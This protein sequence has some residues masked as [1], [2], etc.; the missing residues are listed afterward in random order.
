MDKTADFDSKTDPARPSPA[1]RARALALR[2]WIVLLLAA[3][4]FVP[5]AGISSYSVIP[6]QTDFM[7]FYAV[8]TLVRIGEGGAAWHDQVLASAVSAAVGHP[9]VGLH[10]LYP[11]GMLFATW[12]LAFLPVIP[13]YLLW[14]AVGLVGAGLV[15]WRLAPRTAL[16]F[17]LPLCPA[18]VYC[19]MTG[20]VS[21]FATALA[22]GAFLLLERRPA[23]AGILLGILTL[24]IQ[25]ALLLPVALLAGRHYRALRWMIA[26]GA[27]IELGAA[28][29]FGF[30]SVLL[31]LQ[32][33][34]GD[35]SY[36]A[37]RPN[38]LFRMPTVYSL[39]VGLTQ[40]KPLA[41]AL[42]TLSGLAAIAL[43]WHAWRRSRDLIVRSL[44]WSA[45][46]VLAVPY[47]FDYDLAIFLIP[48]AAMVA[49]AA[50]EPA[51]IG[52]VAV[53]S[54]LW[55][56][57]FLMKYAAIATG[58]QLAPFGAL[59]LIGYAFW[60]SRCSEAKR[61]AA[62]GGLDTQSRSC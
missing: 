9:I 34:T 15:V 44:A 32:T 33:A 55:S 48:L 43:V 23:L 27:A 16:A 20:Q 42:Q 38:L 53:M 45:A 11:P 59:A 30:D 40:D 39:L 3:S 19:C 49:R 1:G 17:L 26:A 31:W 14:I 61:D 21:L 18:A 62:A 58:F 54:L 29:V 37:I 25:I 50:R 13:A 56:A 5:A 2:A 8:G 4:L 47:L 12:P 10:W 35:L 36:V 24:K 57:A 7:P 22:G 60:L 46:A 41:L 6:W 51:G 28:A 52:A